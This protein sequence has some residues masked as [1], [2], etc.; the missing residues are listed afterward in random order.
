MSSRVLGLMVS[1]KVGDDYN[2]ALARVS[3]AVFAAIGKE[4]TDENYEQQDRKDYIGAALDTLEE[5]H[6]RV[7]DRIENDR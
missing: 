6:G 7:M 1:G 5:I 3:Q 4:L 2:A